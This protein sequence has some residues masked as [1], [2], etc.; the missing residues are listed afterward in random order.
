[1]IKVVFHSNCY[2]GFT[3]AWVARQ[4]FSWQQV[5]FIPA[6]YGDPIP[7]FSQGD[8]V[9]IV[10]FS[11][12]RDVLEKIHDTVSLV[13]V[14][15]H[16]HTAK[17]ALSG[18]DYCLF[19]MERSGAK[20]AWDYFTQIVGKEVPTPPLVAYVED[21]DLWRWKLPNSREINHY[22][23]S[24]PM[25]FE[26]WDRLNKDL[27]GSSFETCVNIGEA[28]ARYSD[29]KVEEAIKNGTQWRE[30]GGYSIPCVNVPYH[31]GSTVGN[32][33]LELHP[34]APFSGYYLFNSKG[35]E[36]WGL[37]GRDSDDFDVSEIAK[38]YGGGGHKKASGFLMNRVTRG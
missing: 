33:L 7:E 6:S 4:R 18:L 8:E 24:F 28:I 32:R 12:P 30:I 14:L 37:R 34:S 23:S 17:E 22:I 20:L 15:D 13:Q 1:M 10:D 19:D 16:H 29:L 11:Y 36:Q 38:Q 25:T 21:R 3:A 2:D 26:S 5:E 35:D 9:Y 31:M 27:S